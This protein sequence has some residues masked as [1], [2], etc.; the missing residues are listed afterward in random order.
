MQFS[1][2]NLITLQI[3]EIEKSIEKSMEEINS[4]IKTIPGIGSLNGAMI[5]SE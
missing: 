3:T 2:L 4:V 1:K 5:I